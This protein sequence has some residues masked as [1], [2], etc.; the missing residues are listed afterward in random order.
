VALE[1]FVDDA[2]NATGVKHYALGRFAHELAYV[3]PAER[4]V[5]MTDDETNG[6]LF[7]FVAD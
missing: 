1:V 4:T 6:A 2:G 5:Y 7:L 3:I